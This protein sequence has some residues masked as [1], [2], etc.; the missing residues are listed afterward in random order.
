M[1]V[2]VPLAGALDAGALPDAAEG[3]VRWKCAL[4]NNMPDAAFGA[5]E[6]QFEGLL[7]AGSGS[8]TVVVTRHT[9]VGVP[10]G[11]RIWARIAAEYR[12][13]EAI[14]ANPPDLLIVPGS[15]PI[16]S[17]IEDEPYWSDL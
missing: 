15:D 13:L 3:S 12:P 11:E 14:P 17:R 5:T 7:N 1:T 8:E 4:V 2:D 16:E 10:R 6:R 9:M